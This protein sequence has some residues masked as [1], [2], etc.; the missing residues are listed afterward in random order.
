MEGAGC[1]WGSKRV[2][3]E[4]NLQRRQI[5][6]ALMAGGMALSM[7]RTFGQAPERIPRIGYVRNERSPDDDI[8][9][10]REGLRELGYQEGRN[11]AVE[12]RWG[13]GT[14]ARLQALVDELI[15]LKVDVLVASAPQASEAAKASTRSIPV[16][17]V[18]VAD[19]VGYGLVGSY[20]RPG[21][22]L[23]GFAFLL[24]EICGKRLELLKQMLPS[25]SRVAVMWNGRNP[26]KKEDLRHVQDAAR[27]LRVDVQQIPVDGVADLDRAFATAM[28]SR[29]GGLITLE[30]PFTIFNARAIATLA[31]R[32][33]LPALY[34][35]KP[36]VDAGGLMYYGP[37]RRDQ[38]RRSAR[39]VDRLLKGAR[40][41][42]IPV[43]RPVK[44]ELIVNMKAARTL[45]LK[46]PQSILLQADHLIE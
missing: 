9:G 13:D 27:T 38:N 29:P 43:E 14:A 35:V 44:F 42:D 11:I 12:Y 28:K 2:T 6:G 1:A 24:P 41:Q 23:T 18:L 10:F 31:A 36:Y 20:S 22:N 7:D 37:D 19:P 45:G 15:G 46:I 32:H 26:L 5:L 40:P 3:D 17:M 16:V 25:L 30:D 4:M 34:G 21:G 8:E 33:R 39:V